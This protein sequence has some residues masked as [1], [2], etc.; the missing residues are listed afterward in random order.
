MSLTSNILKRMF[1]NLLV[2]FYKKKTRENQ[3]KCQIDG[4]KSEC[5]TTNTETDFIN[6]FRY[7]TANSSSSLD[8]V[9]ITEV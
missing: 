9:R 1:N 7:V 2:L 3:S 8:S 4:W 6:D 5:K